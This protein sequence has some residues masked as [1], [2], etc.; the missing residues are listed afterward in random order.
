MMDDF[1]SETDSDYTSYWRDWVSHGLPS[2]LGYMDD[3]VLRSTVAMND[4]LNYLLSTTVS[5][6]PP[7]YLFQPTW[8]FQHTLWQGP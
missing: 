5:G 6:A 8:N 2:L 4:V 7:K 1:A 3:I